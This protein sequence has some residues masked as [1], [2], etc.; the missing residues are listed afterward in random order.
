MSQLGI[1]QLGLPLSRGKAIDTSR[2]YGFDNLP[3]FR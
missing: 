2:E 1:T 3:F